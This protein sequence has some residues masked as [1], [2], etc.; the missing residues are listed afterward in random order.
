M[1]TL[2]FALAGLTA[3]AVLLAAPLQADAQTI[4]RCKDAADKTVLQQTPCADG[5]GGAVAVPTLNVV[6]SQPAGEAGLRAQVAKERI[7]SS[8]LQR[9]MSDDEVVRVLGRPTL[10]NS[11]YVDGRVSNQYVYRY[12]DGSERYVYVNDQGLYAVQNRP[13][14]EPVQQQRQP[15]YS[16]LDLRNAEVGISS[17]TLP[18][19]EIA[20]RRA[21][22]NEMRRCR[23]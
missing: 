4:Y 13:A 9:G 3:A 11:D 1:N 6:E 8:G 12:G 10:I 5:R 7:G 23:R 21:R 14:L 2:I 19:E 17:V 22:L 15:C 20:R 18:P 16:E